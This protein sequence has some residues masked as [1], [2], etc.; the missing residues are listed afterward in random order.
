M[1]L[2]ILAWI[3]S[4][5]LWCNQTTCHLSVILLTFL[6]DFWYL[7]FDLAISFSLGSHMQ[8]LIHFSYIW[9]TN[10]FILSPNL[11]LYDN[12]SDRLLRYVHHPSATNPIHLFLKESVML[13]HHQHW[14]Q[15]IKKKNYYWVN[16]DQKYCIA[17][18]WFQK[19][20][21]GTIKTYDLRKKTKERK[22]IENF[23]FLYWLQLTLETSK[24]E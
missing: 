5:F 16:H 13:R 17:R 22:E 20:G 6:F 4:D 7:L 12:T 2:L 23:E 21:K 9:Q 3:L 19:Y 10:L 14:K 11:T 24:S 18:I 8:V 1:Y 15:Y